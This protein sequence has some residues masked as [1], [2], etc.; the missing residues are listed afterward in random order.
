[1]RRSY[2]IGILTLAAIAAACSSIQKAAAPPTPSFG[3]VRNELVLCEANEAAAVCEERTR[4][5]L[6]H[7]WGPAEQAELRYFLARFLAKQGRH[8]KATLLLRDLPEGT[9]Y[10]RDGRKL[11]AESAFASGDWNGAIDFSL[12]VYLSLSPEEKVPMSRIVFLSYL[13]RGD[14]EKAARWYA[15]LSAE[16]RAV[17]DREK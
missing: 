12:A 10:L 2:L 9:H 14:T 7:P 13:Y 16:K 4:D 1:M 5:N 8:D 11:G 17:S 15:K 6:R 3:A